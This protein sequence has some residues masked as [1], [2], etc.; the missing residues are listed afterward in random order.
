MQSPA[1][2]LSNGRCADWIDARARVE[3]EEGSLPHLSQRLTRRLPRPPGEEEGRR[4][5]PTAGHDR[6]QGRRRRA[7]RA[8]RR[9]GRR[10]AQGVHRS[11]ERVCEGCWCWCARGL[12]KGEES[13]G[14]GRRD[15]VLD[16]AG[17]ESGGERWLSVVGRGRGLALCRAPSGDGGVGGP[18]SARLNRLAPHKTTSPSSLVR[19]QTHTL[20]SSP[21]RILVTSVVRASL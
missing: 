19:L 8:R 4:C 6:R 20:G 5:L 15:E 11:M 2:A 12:C 17:A 3:S 18:E 21:L 13:G 14:V 10:R 1:D 16:A 7:R 9:R